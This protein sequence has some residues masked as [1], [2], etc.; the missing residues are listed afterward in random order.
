M[1]DTFGTSTVDPEAIADAVRNVFDLR[2]GAIIAQLDLRRPIYK[3]TAAY[4]HFGRTDADG[5]T[6]ERTD[7]V[8]D[9][10]SALGL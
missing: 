10:K 9:L 6:W 2:P 5:F 4:G 1:V 3:R 7:R 8:D